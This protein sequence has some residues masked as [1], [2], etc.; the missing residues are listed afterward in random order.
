LKRG[1][2]ARIKF[3]DSHINKTLAF[4]IRSLRG[5]LS[6]EKAMEKLGM[7]Q[8]AISRLENPYY[9]KATLT[10]LKR[11]ASAYD[12]G[13]LVEFVPYSRLMDRVSGTPFFDLGL[14][15]NTMNVANFDAELSELESQQIGLE[16]PLA[17]ETWNGIVRDANASGTSLGEVFN[18]TAPSASGSVLP[19]PS[20]DL[21]NVG[22]PPVTCIS[23]SDATRTTWQTETRR[24]HGDR[25]RISS[26][27]RPRRLSRRSIPRRSKIRLR[28]I[29]A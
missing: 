8:N 10:T 2:D 4:Q 11:I 3:V 1:P 18:V 5:E 20:S 7:N 6:Q 12:I 27:A 16:T 9:G 14:N 15:P 29:H 17:T 22:A 26:I 21:V 28:G 13:L 23:N 19:I 24:Q 25:G